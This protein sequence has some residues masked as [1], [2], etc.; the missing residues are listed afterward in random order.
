M[1]TV[2]HACLAGI[3]SEKGRTRF[4]KGRIRSDKVGLVGQGWTRSEKVGQDR[5]YRSDKFVIACG[6][7]FINIHDNK[8]LTGYKVLP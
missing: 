3:K 4:D 6:R 7:D 5:T 8:S 2:S 1:T